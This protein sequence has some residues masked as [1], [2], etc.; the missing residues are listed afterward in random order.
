MIDARLFE[1]DG[2]VYME[3]TCAAHG[4]FRDKIYSDA[5]LYLKMEQ[6]EFGDNRGLEN[7][8]VPGRHALSGR[9]RSLF[10]AH[11]AHGSFQRGS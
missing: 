9:L 8:A 6:W 7:P 2:A 3:K 5:R 11:L 1:E 10:A 4:D